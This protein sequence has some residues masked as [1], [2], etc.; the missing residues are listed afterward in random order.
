MVRGNCGQTK[1]GSEV[2]NDSDG[3][4]HGKKLKLGIEWKNF[5]RPRDQRWMGKSIREMIKVDNLGN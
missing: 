4:K 2:D 5:Q 1:F 3:G